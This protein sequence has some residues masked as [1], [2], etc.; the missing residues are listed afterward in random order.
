MSKLEHTHVELE[1]LS[2]WVDGRMPVGTGREIERH[3]AIC[4]SCSRKRERLVDLIAEARALPDTIEPPAELWNAVRGRLSAPS[5][6]KSSLGARGRCACLF[7][8]FLGSG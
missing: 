3:L 4:E 1:R 5:A 8:T 2:D 7:P 6:T